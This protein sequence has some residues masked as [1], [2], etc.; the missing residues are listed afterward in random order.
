[1]KFGKF[2]DIH[3]KW[4]WLSI[5][6]NKTLEYQLEFDEFCDQP[7]ELSI[8]WTAKQDHAGI[9]FTFSIYRLFWYQLS[10]H[11]NRHWNIDDDRW[12]DPS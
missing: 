9:V 4:G 2:G 5:T 8:K 1:M 10:L 11:D 12:E 7:L 6:K 3:F